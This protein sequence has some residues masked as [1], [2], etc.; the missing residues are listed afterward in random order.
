MLQ[1]KKVGRFVRLPAMKPA[2][3]VGTGGKEYALGKR[4]ALSWE[5]CKGVSWVPLIYRGWNG[6]TT[7]E[8][9]SVKLSSVSAD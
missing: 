2:G 3:V 6:R 4:F 1:P 5:T 9:P 8:A 7:K